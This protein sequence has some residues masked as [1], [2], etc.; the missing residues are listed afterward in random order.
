MNPGSRLLRAVSES[1]I[2][3]WLAYACDLACPIVLLHLGLSCS[4][5][6]PIDWLALPT[7]ILCGAFVFSFV[8][9]SMHR[10]LFH[11]PVSFATAIHHK[12]HVYPR[13]ATAMPFPCSAGAAF[14][15]WSYLPFIMSEQSTCF[16][17]TGFLT[18]YFY[19]TVIHHL[20]HTIRITDLRVRC[21]R[22]RWKAHAVHHAKTDKNYG[23]TTAFWD[24]V[25]GTYSVIASKTCPARPSLPTPH[26]KQDAP[27]I[28]Q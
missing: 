28:P 23:V 13:D 25:F 3:Y 6:H 17:A 21:Y 26:S 22:G 5:G 12:H 9:Y 27:P 15:L 24:R 20:Q 10:W 8:E 7:M 14:L 11:A 18:A 2:N 1:R 16:F 4:A 19:Y